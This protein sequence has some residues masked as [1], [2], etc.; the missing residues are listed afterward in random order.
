MLVRRDTLILIIH[1]SIMRL[2]TVRY[3]SVF[4]VILVILLALLFLPLGIYVRASGLLTA[5]ETVDVAVSVGTNRASHRSFGQNRISHRAPHTFASTTHDGGN[6]ILSW[7]KV[8]RNRI[9]DY[10]PTLSITTPRSRHL[11]S[12]ERGSI[13]FLYIER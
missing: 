11:W 5:H 2:I 12:V 4:Y 8:F 9:V 3:H 13:V 10:T 7:I 1:G 6:T